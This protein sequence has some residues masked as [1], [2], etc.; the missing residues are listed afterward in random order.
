MIPALRGAWFWAALGAALAAASARA[1]RPSAAMLS[2][3]CAACHGT[4][5]ASAGP[6]VP[7]IGGQPALYI[8]ASLNAFRDGRRPSSVMGRIAKGFARED[9]IVIGQF[10]AAQAYLPARQTVDAA[11]AER[12]RRVHELRCERCHADGGRRFE[13]DEAK[14]P[15]PILAGQWLQYLQIVLRE[16]SERERA[17]PAGMDQAFRTL[18]RGD[19]EALAHFY[20]SR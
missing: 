17:L 14:A 9:F 18:E 13:S 8:T 10:Y 4:R 2:E 19:P 6:A 7:T 11:L 1:D 16:F 5:G 12:G 20:A 15:G 3:P